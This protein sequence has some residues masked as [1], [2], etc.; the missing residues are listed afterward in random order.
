MTKNVKKNCNPPRKNIHLWENV[1]EMKKIGGVFKEKRKELKMTLSQ[2]NNITKIDIALLSKIERGE[3]IATKVQF[4]LIC[5]A[6]EINSKLIMADY[7]SDSI[8]DY[9][10]DEDEYLIKKAL[11]RVE[12]SIFYYGRANSS[13]NEILTKIDKL[14]NRLDKFRPFPAAQ[15]K[16]LEQF[17]KIEYTFD[18]NRI[19]GN[20]LT[21]RE[22]AM[23]IEKGITI[24]GKPLKEHLEAINHSDAVDYIMDLVI[25]KVELSEKILKEIHSL[26]LRGIDKENAG[27]Y[28][29]LNVRIS[30]SSHLPPAHFIVPEKMDQY[31]S[32]Y[33]NNKNVLHP[34]VL[35][36]DMHEKLVT[37]HPFID[38][39][40]RTSRL[41]MNLILL[42]N[43]YTL[44]NISGDKKNR[45]SYYDALEAVQIG[46][47]N[48]LFYSFI[49]EAVQKSLLNHLEI[50]DAGF[51]VD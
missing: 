5:N 34:I 25:N 48:N 49:S 18:S 47:G 30:G 21:H 4:L 3:R 23:V 19:E 22:T 45:M 28:R 31:F 33:Q 2:I 46:N 51:I 9:L 38:G 15:L 24:D 50:V 8:I 20:T 37:I 27:R 13:I 10:K 44:A 12:E 42:Q 32:F 35:A 6:L 26:V 41:V 29:Q 40:G 36:A 17:F 14:K 11:S 1:E 7:L 39:N 43:G 16:N